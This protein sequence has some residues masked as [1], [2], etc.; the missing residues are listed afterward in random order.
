[1]RKKS[2]QR[3]SPVRAKRMLAEADR[4]RQ[5]KHKGQIKAVRRMSGEDPI[6]D[7]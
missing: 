2:I 6:L 1:M 3:I 5:A 4:G 7:R